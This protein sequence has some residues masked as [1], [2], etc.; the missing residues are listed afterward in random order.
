MAMFDVTKTVIETGR[1]KLSEML[2]KIDT[3]WMQGDITDDERQGLIQM[4]KQSPD[5]RA[6]LDVLAKLEDLDRRVA[7]LESGGGRG[8]EAEEYPEYVAGKW[9]YNGGKMTYNGKRYTCIVP[10]GVVCVWN[11]DE[12]ATYWEEVTA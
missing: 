6:E 11:P 10:A 3:I 8:G 2:K 9:Y 12:Y 1:Y 5:A 7:A 4:A